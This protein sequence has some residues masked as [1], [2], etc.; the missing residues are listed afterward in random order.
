MAATARPPVLRISP[1]NAADLGIVDGDEVT[2]TGQLGSLTLP[3][4][5]TD[6]PAGVVWVPANSGTNVLAQVGVTSGD[7]V[8]VSVGRMS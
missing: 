7:T 3:A 6:M 4:L 2:I 8:R 1:V 5:L